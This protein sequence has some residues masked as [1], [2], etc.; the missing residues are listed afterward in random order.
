MNFLRNKFSFKLDLYFM[1]DMH[2]NTLYKMW[3]LKKIFIFYFFILIEFF[4]DF[5]T[6]FLNQA[7]LD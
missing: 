4:F 2:A 3:A 6:K 1:R 7:C 5:L